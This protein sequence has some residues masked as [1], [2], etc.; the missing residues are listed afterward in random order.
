MTWARWSIEIFLLVFDLLDTYSIKKKK[1]EI[2]HFLCPLT[3]IDSDTTDSD[4]HKP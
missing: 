1:V 3:A 2:Y 4:I